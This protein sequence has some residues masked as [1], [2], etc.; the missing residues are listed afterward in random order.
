MVAIEA[1]THGLATVA[2]A[3]GGITDA[4][5]EKVS[6]RLVPADDSAAFAQAVLETLQNP[7]NPDGIRQFA[8]R[9]AWP[10]FG[11]SIAQVLLQHV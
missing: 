8:Q 5:S 11:K 6:G 10:E 1:A 4:V 7:L 3:T 2:Y 9:F